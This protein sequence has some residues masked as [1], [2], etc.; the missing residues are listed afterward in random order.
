MNVV[1]SSSGSCISF[2]R[3]LTRRHLLQVG[4]LGLLGFHLPGL[5]RAAEHSGKQK[6]RARAVIFLHQWGGPS[7]HDS[8]DMKPST[9][10]AIRGEF[11]PISTNLPSVPVCDQLPDMA[12]VMNKVTLVRTLHHTMKNHNSA[13][14]YSLSGYAPATDDQR[15]RDSNDLF[16]AYGSIVDRLAP[17]RAGVPTFVSYPHTISDGSITPGQ[18][19]TFLGKAHDPLFINQ[20]P[21]SPDFRLPELSLPENISLERLDNRR[22]VLRLIDRQTEL[23]EFSAKARGIDAQYQ[24]AMTMLSSPAIKKAF[25]LTSEPDSV[26]RRYGRTTYGQGCLLAR[27]VVEAGA[28]FVNVYFART[29]GGQGSEGG[30]DTHGF[31]N[32]PMYPVL[33]NYL[34]PIT[35]QT[36]PTLLEDLDQRGLLDETLVV[37]VG[38]FGRSPRINKMAGRDH[39]PQ[40]YTALL[41]GGGVKRG[42]VHGASDKIG[43]YPALDPVRPDDLA[44]TMFHLLG[45]DPKTEIRDALNRPLPISSGEVIHGVLA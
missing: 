35:N 1:K 2:S 21:N 4:G 29:I 45:I 27:R 6:A 20:D 3:P 14:Y 40:C 24:R 44:A 26:R 11:K 15:L 19:A 5:L 22:D 39:W 7:H 38:E 32:K 13:G 36:L 9:P 16:P 41:A 42:H 43:A 17:A 34:M 33:K 10:E 25:D 8:F 18:H 30:W 37:W 31:N 12:R 23:M 28:R